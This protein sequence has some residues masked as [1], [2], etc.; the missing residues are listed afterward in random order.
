MLAELLRTGEVA[1]V[2]RTVY[3]FKPYI[4]KGYPIGISLAT[5]GRVLRDTACAA[6][7]KGHPD[8]R[9]VADAFVNET[10]S[11]EAQTRM[12]NRSGSG[13]PTAR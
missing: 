1:L 4:E 5:E 6:I 2:L 11:V 8:K 7:V 9:E 3:L 12:A 10:L 13:R